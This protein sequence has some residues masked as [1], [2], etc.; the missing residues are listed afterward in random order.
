MGEKRSLSQ[1]WDEYRP[2][3]T[4]WFWSCVACIVATIVVGFAWGGWV[5]AG[6]AKNMAE[7]AAGKAQ[8]QLVASYCVARFEGSADAATQL[9]TLK[10][11][12]SWGQDD[13]ITKGG[14][15]TPPGA[16]EPTDGAADL[17]VQRLLTAKL[18]PAATGTAAKAP[19]TGG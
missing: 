8:A 19:S 11:T 10:N 13:V 14:W 1:R 15:V 18:V 3:K 7:D 5:T 6:T 9:A 16:K 17:C 12:Q 4:G 2:S